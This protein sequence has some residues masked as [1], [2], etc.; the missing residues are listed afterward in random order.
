MRTVVSRSWIWGGRRKVLSR[1]EGL[2]EVVGLEVVTE[3]VRAGTRWKIWREW[4]LALSCC[5]PRTVTEVITV[6]LAELEWRAFGVAFHRE[7]S[8]PLPSNRHRR[9]NGDCLEGKR[10]DYQ[11][12]SVQY[13]AQQLC[14]VQRTHIWTELTVLW[15]GFCLNGPILL[16]LDSF[17]MFITVYCMHV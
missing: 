7:S 10:E 8:T 12:C 2:L 3:S 17:C 11:V 4:I 5:W 9:S 1:L 14:T 6:L 13:C 15:I 16:F